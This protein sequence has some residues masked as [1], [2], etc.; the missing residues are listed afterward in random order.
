[1]VVPAT[2]WTAEAYFSHV[3]G[4]AAS[5]SGPDL[6]PGKPPPPER[7]QEDVPPRPGTPPDEPMAPTPAPPQSPPPEPIEPPMW[8]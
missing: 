3:Q 7:P 2:Q 6:P 4:V 1:M 8:A 5:R